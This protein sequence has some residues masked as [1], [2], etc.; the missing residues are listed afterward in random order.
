MFCLFY[1]FTEYS[2]SDLSGASTLLE[3]FYTVATSAS[4]SSEVAAQPVV[5]PVPWHEC[6]VRWSFAA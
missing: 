4:L 6:D 2:C 5:Q 1:L 3:T